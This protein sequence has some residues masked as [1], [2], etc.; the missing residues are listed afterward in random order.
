MKIIVNIKCIH[1]HYSFSEHELKLLAH[2]KKEAEKKTME[3]QQVTEKLVKIEFHYKK[4]EEDMV[5]VRERLLKIQKIEMDLSKLQVQR[6]ELS[7]K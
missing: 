4:C 7:T 1:Y 6:I 3:L 2:I 5:P